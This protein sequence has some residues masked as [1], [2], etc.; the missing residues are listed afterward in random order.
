M[1]EHYRSFS[2]QFEFAIQINTWSI[3]VIWS[4]CVTILLIFD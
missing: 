4:T 3:I 1:R 2:R